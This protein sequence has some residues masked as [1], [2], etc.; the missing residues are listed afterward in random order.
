[1]EAVLAQR[2]HGPP[3]F[4]CAITTPERACQ[5]VTDTVLAHSRRGLWS[6]LLPGG[7]AIAPGEEDVVSPRK[8]RPVVDSRVCVVLQVMVAK[9]AEH[10]TQAA[11]PIC[12][13]SVDRSVN[14]RPQV[15]VEKAPKQINFC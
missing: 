10:G 11:E 7:A 6:I 1:V 3:K 2:G 9:E 8:H 4:P 13:H 12:F 15:G 14:A 5:F